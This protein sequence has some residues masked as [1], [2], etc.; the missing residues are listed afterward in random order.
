M[1]SGMYIDIAAHILTP[2][3]K[4]RYLELA[5]ETKNHTEMTKPAVSD[6]EVRL[7]FMDRY[8]RVLQVLT[9]A[10]L[11]IER[12]IKETADAVELARI[13]N[14]ELAD[15]VLRYP[16]KFLGAAAILPMN[17][18]N[19]ACKE[20]E[21]AL[22]ECGLLGIELFTRINGI[23]VADERFE[24]IFK[25]ANDFGVPI[26][27]HPTNNPLV[28]RES[29][30]FG[31]EYELATSMEL[32]VEAG[33]Y[34]KFPDIR[35]IIH[36]AG[37][38]IPLFAGRIKYLHQ[39]HALPHVSKRWEDFHKFYVDTALYGNTY[40]LMDSYSFFGAQRLL[41][42]TDAP[43]GPK[44]GMTEGTIESIDRMDITDEEKR[45]IFK[46]NALDMF[47]LVL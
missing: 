33:I 41:F 8:P 4:K 9:V 31:W 32:L 22:K 25:I 7:R 36:H 29:P 39:S 1:Y 28:E 16:D 30:L 12:Y 26:W 45:M 2:K 38:L 34:Q 14:D 47:C 35:I 10:N 40:G 5:P 21:R 15:I 24:P 46:Q 42:G 27:I 19:E 17:D 23:S 3:F 20:A 37:S 11:P 18:V 43:L 6:L 13:G 44:W